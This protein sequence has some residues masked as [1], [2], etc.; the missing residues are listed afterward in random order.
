MINL[1]DAIK[2]INPKA[3]CATIDED[4]DKIIWNPNTTP[5]SK[6]DILAKKSELQADYDSK[7]YQRDRKVEYPSVEDYLDGIVKDDQT[8]IDKYIAD[9]KAVKEKYP[10]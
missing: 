8:Q 1:L 5:I 3:E 7:K 9:C 6:E 2:S 4:V 10:K